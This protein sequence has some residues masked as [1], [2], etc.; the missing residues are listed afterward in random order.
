[1]ERLYETTFILKPDLEEE[2]RDNL[3]ERIKNIIPD[4][5][6]EIVEV[7][8][9]GKRKLAYEINDYRTGFYTVIVFRGN[10]EVVNELER[11]FKIIDNVLRSLVIR[12]EK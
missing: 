9:W 10:V 11:N 3:L 1:M 6:G 4:N 2:D 7:D 8:I 12:K 5:G